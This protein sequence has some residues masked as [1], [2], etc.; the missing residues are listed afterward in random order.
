MDNLVKLNKAKTSLKGSITRM[1][2]FF[3]NLS[4]DVDKTL[5]DVKL[6][7]IDQLQKKLEELKEISFGIE[8]ATPTEE[9]EF[10]D[11]LDN[12]EISL[13]D[14]E[15]KNSHLVFRCKKFL[16]LDP[17]RRLDLVRLHKLCELCLR[18]NHKKSACFS[19]YLCPCG[20]RHSR[21]LCTGAIGDQRKG[22]IPPIQP[23]TLTKQEDGE[24]E[25]INPSTL[26]TVLNNVAAQHR[27]NVLVST[28]S[29]FLRNNEGSRTKM[30]RHF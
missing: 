19:T 22:L 12:C 23:Q 24:F 2:T 7:K 16:E 18:K 30:P 29:I 17:E 9:A 10:E 14:L 1:E 20:N 26:N 25:V 6:K 28:G 4:E 13:E 11:D 8:T 15:K 21:S 27:K 3:D 5:L